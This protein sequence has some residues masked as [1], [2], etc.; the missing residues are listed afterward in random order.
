MACLREK[1]IPFS[2]LPEARSRKECVD[3]IG[4]LKGYAFIRQQTD[5]QNHET[6]YDMH[7]LI[8]VAIRNWLSK[9]DH[10]SDQTIITIKQVEAIFPW[11]QHRHRD[12]FTL[13]M[14]HVRALCNSPSGKSL[15]ERYQLLAKIGDCFLRLGHYEDAVHI[16]YEVLKWRERLSADSHVDI[17]YAQAEL[18]LYLL[19][20]GNLTKAEIYLQKAV[21]GLTEALGLLHVETLRARGDLARVYSAQGQYEKAQELESQVLEKRKQVLG[22]E[23]PDTLTSMNNLASTYAEQGQYRKARNLRIHVLDSTRRAFG[24]EHPDT[25]TSKSNLANTYADQG[26]YEKARNLYVEVLESERLMLGD[27][28]PETLRSMSNLAYIYSEQDEY[29]KAQELE[30]QVLA[31]RKRILGDEHPDT[32]TSINNLA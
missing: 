19:H 28:H 18:G 8:H 32:L 17:S 1:N 30:R 29:P 14:P 12:M 24:D 9:N 13:Y 5:P 23:H 26:Q 11:G 31:L 21:N 27:E 2:L 25:Q 3:A 22:D 4:V 20:Q 7:R 10:L 15:E 6:L 16:G